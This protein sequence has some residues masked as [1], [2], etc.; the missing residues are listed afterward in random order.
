MHRHTH[1]QRPSPLSLAAGVPE[2]LL[3][4]GLLAALL[5]AGV[6]WAVP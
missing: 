5:W 4:A 1:H 3:L 6:A 2:R